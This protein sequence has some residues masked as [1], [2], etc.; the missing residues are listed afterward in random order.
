MAEVHPVGAAPKAEP[1]VERHHV[2]GAVED[3]LVA[4]GLG[5]ARQEIAYQRAADPRALPVGRHRDILDVAR[6]AR[7]V[8]ELVLDQQ[9]GGADHAAAGHRHRHHAVRVAVQ[10]PEHLP[11]PLRSQIAGWPQRIQRL[12]KPVVQVALRQRTYRHLCPEPS[13]R[14]RHCSQ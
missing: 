12:Q 6:P 5:G 2:V 14:I 13:V 4:A 3:G 7:L 11:R 9:R 1:L 10:A 8:D